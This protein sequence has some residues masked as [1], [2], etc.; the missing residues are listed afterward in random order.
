M[1]L[2]KI[3]GS[4]KSLERKRAEFEQE[5][6]VWAAIPYHDNVQPLIGWCKEPFCMVTRLMANGTARDYLA[7]K[8]WHRPAIL[9]VLFGVARGMNH[10]HS[11][12]T[13][14]L[15]SDLKGANVLVDENGTAKVADFGLSKIRHGSTAGHTNFVGGN[16]VWANRRGRA[17]DVYAFGMMMWEFWS[18]GDMPL[19]DEMEEEG[20][21]LL[22]LGELIKKDPDFRPKRPDLC[23]DQVWSLMQWC[24][25]FDPAARPNFGEVADA[26]KVIIDRT[27][28]VFIK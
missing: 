15:H 23:P 11:R 9:A 10:L 19:E 12:P 28:V 3:D 27:D 1:K 8:G 18:K 7:K 20:I 26:L 5:M 21:M 4:P 13:P 16:S 14:I 22:H 25:A 24:W 6:A 2:V 17:S